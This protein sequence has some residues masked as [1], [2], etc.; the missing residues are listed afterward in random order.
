MHQKYIKL[1]TELS[2][3]VAALSQQVMDYNKRKN[4][5]K[6]EETARIM[7]DQYTELYQKFTTP[8]FSTASLNKTDFLRLLVGAA[9]IKKNI[10][11]RIAEEKNAVKG[12]ETDV[13]PK[14]QQLADA[15]DEEIH[16]LADKLLVISEDK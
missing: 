13:I 8:G 16:A 9:I 10:E 4:E 12:Y 11:D 1:F 5:T 15:P 6:G 7:Y 3:T 14:L 2:H